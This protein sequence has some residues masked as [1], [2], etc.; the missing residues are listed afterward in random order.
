MA[1]VEVAQWSIEKGAPELRPEGKERANPTKIWENHV[2]RRGN[3]HRKVPEAGK[4][5]ECLRNSKKG[6]MVGAERVDGELGGDVRMGRLQ[7]PQGGVQ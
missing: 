4:S 6:G 7:W 3:G 2:P 5:C 1:L